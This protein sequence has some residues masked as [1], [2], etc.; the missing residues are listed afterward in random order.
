MI[1]C[2]RVILDV[3][4]DVFRDIEIKSDTKLED[5]HNCITQSFGFDGSEL[6]SFYKSNTQWEQ[7]EE[8][9]LFDM[10]EM[11]AQQTR[12]MSEVNLHEIIDPENENGK[13]LI[14]IYDHFSMWT[15]MVEL[16][17]TCEA[18]SGKSYPNVL[19]SHGQ[20]PLEIPEKNFEAAANN[21]NLDEHD[22]EDD[23]YPRSQETYHS[24]D[25]LYTDDLWN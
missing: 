24:S 13:Q 20:T 18:I 11:G 12:L 23:L 14:Y 1:Y 17:Q 21:G 2:F 3:E 16:V 6:A 7:G 4:Q 25:S 8:V 19:Y 22:F 9:S 15:F 10:S 5:F